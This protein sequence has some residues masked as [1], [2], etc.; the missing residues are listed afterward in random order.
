LRQFSLQALQSLFFKKYPKAHLVHLLSLLA[1][2]ATHCESV[3]VHLRQYL[4]E[5]T[6][7]FE[8]D[9]HD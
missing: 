4:F 5:M 3:V 8:H 6:K 7:P 1:W 9:V 2:Q